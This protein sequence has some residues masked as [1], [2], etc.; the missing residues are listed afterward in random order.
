MSR[1]TP[2]VPHVA[3]FHSRVRAY[4]LPICER[5][6][7][8]Y[9]TPCTVRG[10]R[11]EINNPEGKASLEEETLRIGDVY[12]LPSQGDW[13]QMQEKYAKFDQA[14]ISLAVCLDGMGSYKQTIERANLKML[15]AKLSSTVIKAHDIEPDRS[16]SSIWEQDRWIIPK[17]ERVVIEKHTPKKLRYADGSMT[18]QANHFIC[19]DDE[20]WSALEV[21][22]KSAIAHHDQWIDYLKGLGSYQDAEL[23]QRYK[24]KLNSLFS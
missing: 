6:D 9:S 24:A 3:V 14:L 15:P 13:T 23:D 20:A 22:Y 10:K 21:V 7:V 19:K 4:Q 12:C 8:L 1:Q 16:F 5:M 17:V 11:E 18:D 2:I